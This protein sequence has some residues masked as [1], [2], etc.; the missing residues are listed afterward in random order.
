MTDTLLNIE[1][2]NTF[3]LFGGGP[4]L[5]DLAKH[6]QANGSTVY[7]FTS[8][9][10]IDYSGEEANIPSIMESFGIPCTITANIGNDEQAKGIASAGG[11]GISFGAPW[12][13]RSAFIDLWNGRLLNSHPAPL[14]QHRGGGGYSWRILMNDQR[15]ATCVHIVTTGLDEGDIVW[16]EQYEFSDE[17]QVP[18]DYEAAQVAN[19]I[20][21][22]RSLTEKFKQGISL[23]LTEQDHT[24]STY[25]PRLETD[26]H[27][28]VDWS[29]PAD[30]IIRSIRAF[31]KPYAGVSTTLNETTVR[32]SGAQ[33]ANDDLSFHPFQAGL[34]YRS[35]EGRHFVA[36][37]DVG[38]SV[39]E[40]IIRSST[41]QKNSVRLGDRLFTPAS[42]LE[43]AREYRAIYR[44]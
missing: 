32:I 22:L 41:E 25:F 11:I 3:A 4:V 8:E 10:L 28:W 21:S 24:T 20:N 18:A 37:G 23:D 5:V 13:F 7:V 39:E 1:P 14:P 36:C 2:T 15:G 33:L 44:P 34:I 16:Y 19:D 6:L 26:T 30:E 17:C 31:D 38:I 9:R 42:K 12:I 29:L 43:S 35:F 27:G 40:I